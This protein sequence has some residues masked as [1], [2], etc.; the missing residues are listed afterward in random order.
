MF[1][2]V[3]FEHVIN[4]RKNSVLAFFVDNEFMGE[5][6]YTEVFERLYSRHLRPDFIIY[7]FPNYVSKRLGQLFKRGGVVHKGSRRFGSGVGF[8]GI[9]FDVNGR[10]KRSF[11]DKI[12][13]DELSE[14]K[15]KIVSFGVSKL[16]KENSVVEM[17]PPGTVFLK[18]SGKDFE[19]FISAGRLCNGSCEEYFLSFAML[20]MMPRD[21]YSIDCFYLDTNSIASMVNSLK[22]MLSR[23]GIEKF[24]MH[25]SFSSYEGLSK[26]KPDN[27][28]GGVFLVSAST[29]GGL[30]DALRKEWMVPEDRIVTI[31]SFVPGDGV[32]CDISHLSNKFPRRAACEKKVKRVGEYFVAEHATPKSVVIKAKHAAGINQSVLSGM[33]DFP[34][35]M[36]HKSKFDNN[37]RE[38]YFDLNNAGRA[39]AAELRAW[40]KDFVIGHLPAAAKWL[41]IDKRDAYNLKAAKSLLALAKAY[42]VYLSLLDIEDVYNFPFNGEKSPV[43][44]F[45]PVVS[46]GDV[47]LSLNRDLRH[48]GH[49]G[50]R[51]FISCFHLYK[52]AA[53]KKVFERSLIYGPNFT[54][55]KFFTKYELSLPNRVGDNSWDS[56]SNFI[57]ELNGIDE[58]DFWLERQAILGKGAGLNGFIGVSGISSSKLLEFSNDFAF[59]DFSYGGKYF[60]EA[61]YATVS[62]VL[63]SAR[64]LGGVGDAESLLGDIYQQ[65]VL[66]PEVFVRFNDPLLQSCFWRAAYTSETDYASDQSLSSQFT[67]IL[68]RLLRNRMNNS[69]EAAIDLL[70]GVAMGRIKL[71]KVSLRKIVD[72]LHSQPALEP[73]FLCLSKYI[74]SKC[75]I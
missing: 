69:G 31:L 1:F 71:S 65:A 49:D 38:I 24:F 40:L 13:L 22:S 44:A 32:L 23:F 33:N 17:A 75:I 29:S 7:V 64:D 59:W 18:P 43:I 28:G 56:E 20:S 70:L 9:E 36:C 67:E 61:V 39:L 51:V 34:I 60:P 57:H 15:K 2:S 6:G 4:G 55:Y 21:K 27:V 73:Q 45:I 41:V 58:V 37:R 72:F 3:D 52:G 8:A 50:L 74:D 11:G 68:I 48:A 5:G 54:K 42:G 25:K 62:S 47:Y 63:Q 10:L 12:N 53:Q 66:S 16:A 19:E 26:D 14:I 30:S 46:S 35:V